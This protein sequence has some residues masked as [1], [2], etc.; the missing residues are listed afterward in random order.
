[1][2]SSKDSETQADEQRDENFP[3]GGTEGP[4]PTA[5]QVL[6]ASKDKPGVQSLRECRNLERGFH[7]ETDNVIAP[8]EGRELST[9]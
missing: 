2:A 8:E 9:Y 1:M 5:R 6:Q 7:S 4:L 3:F